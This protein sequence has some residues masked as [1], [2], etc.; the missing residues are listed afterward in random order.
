MI[1]L[2]GMAAAAAL[3]AWLMRR[4]VRQRADNAAQGSAI[5]VPCLIKHPSHDARWL[6]GRMLTTPTAVVWEPRTK[7]GAGVALPADLRPVGV[8]SPSRRE[9]W[10]INGRSGIV[11]CG[12]AEGTVLV[13]VMPNELDHVLTALNSAGA[14]EQPDG[15]RPREEPGCPGARSVSGRAP[16]EAGTHTGPAS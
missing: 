4:K 7:A 8:R 15:S 6:R 12:S 5:R 9:A 3:T 1:E 14:V 13:A 10:R 11:E 16:K 2:A